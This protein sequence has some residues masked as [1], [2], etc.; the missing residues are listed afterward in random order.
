MKCSLVELR[1]RSTTYSNSCFRPSRALLLLPPCLWWSWRYESIL[2]FVSRCA[3]IFGPPACWAFSVRAELPYTEYCRGR[4]ITVYWFV[5]C[6][7]DWRYW[8]LYWHQ[9]HRWHCYRHLLRLLFSF[10]MIY[11]SYLILSFFLSLSLFAFLLLS[12]RWPPSSCATRSASWWR[13]PS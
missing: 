13:E 2:F 4:N 8:S 10:V 1:N 5:R 3:A 6:F 12:L 11:I 7:F 9:W